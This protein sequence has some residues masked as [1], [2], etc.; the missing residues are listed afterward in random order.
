MLILFAFSVTAE[1]VI[2]CKN[3]EDIKIDKLTN[4]TEYGDILSCDRKVRYI[5]DQIHSKETR[6]LALFQ[7]IVS[8]IFITSWTLAVTWIL[9][10]ILQISRTC[11]FL[12]ARNHERVRRRLDDTDDQH[13]VNDFDANL[14]SRYLD[15][16]CSE[17]QPLLSNKDGLSNKDSRSPF[18]RALNNS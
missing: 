11:R 18:M 8:V 3:V 14:N 13:R 6:S 16:N 1:M 10:T 17:L 15:R 7:G 9:V 2:F 4:S 12:S 5:N